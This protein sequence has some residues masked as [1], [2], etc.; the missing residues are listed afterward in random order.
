MWTSTQ[1]GGPKVMYLKVLVQHN[2]VTFSEVAHKSNWHQRD[3]PME[4][5][6]KQTITIPEAEV[7]VDS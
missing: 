1:T 5:Q 2:A 7:F 3:L 4:S 6:N